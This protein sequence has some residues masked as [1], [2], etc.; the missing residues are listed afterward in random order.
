[1]VIFFLDIV[2][3][4]D[5]MEADTGSKMSINLPVLRFEVVRK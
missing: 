5:V 4:I 2:N 3:A 1:M